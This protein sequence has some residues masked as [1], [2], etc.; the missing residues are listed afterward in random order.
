MKLLKQRPLS[1]IM[2][3]S[4][5][6][7][8]CHRIARYFMKAT[9]F[10]PYFCSERDGVKRS[11]DFKIYF[12]DSSSFSRAIVGTL[13]STLFYWFWRL[14]F[15]GYHCGKENIASFRFDPE[16][17]NKSVISAIGLLVSQLMDGFHNNSERKTVNY[18]GT[19]EVQYDEF[20]VKPCKPIIDEIDCVLAKHY[21]FTD[22]ELDFIINYDIKYRM[23]R[24][25]AEE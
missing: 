16:N 2:R 3:D 10:I 9:D 18:K 23:G 12:S 24:D 19:G 8:Y 20:T 14:M 13:D 11:D 25:N 7:F 22:E 17:A 21:G 5:S 1:V 6:D 4:G 15:D